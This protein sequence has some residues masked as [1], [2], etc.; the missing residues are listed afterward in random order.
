M[1][2]V[3]P[4][5]SLESDL[6]QTYVCEISGWELLT[7]KIILLRIGGSP[8][9]TL[10]SES[11]KILDGMPSFINE[12]ERVIYNSDDLELLDH[13]MYFQNGRK[14]VLKVLDK[15]NNEE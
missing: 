14:E 15:K 7:L 5:T 8:D 11:Q 3:K 1:K 4:K 13:R 10:R 2:I 9:T 12:I 6:N